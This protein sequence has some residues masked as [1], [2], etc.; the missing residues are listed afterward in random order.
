V[1]GKLAGYTI[2]RLRPGLIAFIHTEVG[3]AF[4][5][6]GVGSTLVSQALDDA[7]RRELDVLPLCPFVNSYIQ[8]HPEYLDLVQES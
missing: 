2:Y 4:E 3:D 7:R 1:D 5:G 6:Q 8:K